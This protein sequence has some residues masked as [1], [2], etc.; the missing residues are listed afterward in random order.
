MSLLR[1]SSTAR[2]D[3]F[4]GI[5]LGTSAVKVV[6]ASAHG[7]VLARA[8]R[9]LEL[10]SPSPLAAEQSAEAWWQATVEAL[11]E[12]CDGVPTRDE[13]AAVGLTGQKHALLALDEH[14]TPVAP[15]VIWADGRA[16]E[17]ADE[18]R[19]VFPAIRKRCGSHPLPGFLIPKWLRFLRTHPDVA[20]RAARLLFAKDWIRF[21]LSRS[22][23]TDR[24]EASASQ[25]YDYRSDDWAAELAQVFE[26]HPELPEVVRSTEITGEVTKAAAKL[27]GL[28]AGTPVVAGA[29]DN[30]AAA[31]ACGALGAGR[32]AV[33]LGTSGTVIAENRH[34]TPAGGLVWNRHVRPRGY[35]ATGTILSAGRA[36]DWARGAFYPPG[37]R[38]VEVLRDAEAAKLDAAPL[39]FQPSLVGERSPVPDPHATGAF[40]GLRPGHGRGHLARAVLEGVALGIGEIVVLLRGAGV[41]VDE[42][43]LISGGAASPFWRRLIGAAT[44]VPVR[45]VSHGYGPGLGA[46]LLA[47]AATR[48]HGE[49]DD[50]IARWIEPGPVEEV[51]DALREALTRRAGGL[52]AVRNALR[53]VNP[54]LR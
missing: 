21:R 33:I 26:I 51:D 7:R 39:V 8:K 15:A 18:L 9:K 32:V 24:S 11:R 30:E 29:G 23:A 50:L 34:R 1:R 10:I 16:H 35:A 4:V 17:E 2:S 43:R 19:L 46:A 36:I 52:R 38:M 37:A 12:V 14:G 44:G 28:P 25:L 13:I 48:R 40:V 49:L 42:L 47:A 20:R 3:V 45:F 31:V 5:D 22:F 54:G 27:T 53:G 41:A 6:A